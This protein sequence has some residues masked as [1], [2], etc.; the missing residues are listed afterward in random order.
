[1]SIGVLDAGLGGDRVAALAVGIEE[2]VGD[3]ARAAPVPVSP[4]AVGTP[5]APRAGRGSPVGLGGGA[6]RL[7]VGS[8]GAGMLRGSGRVPVRAAH[9]EALPVV[10]SFLFNLFWIMFAM[11][12]SLVQDLL[13]V[14]L[15]SWG[16][17]C[18]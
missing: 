14:A 2:R 17:R 13:F 5:T 1:M 7:L 9:L 4:L 3:L 12:P 6:R 16:K 8:S 11:A 18:L 10:V 15:R